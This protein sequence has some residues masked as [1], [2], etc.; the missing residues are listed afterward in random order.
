MKI[1]EFI[2]YDP[3]CALIGN[4]SNDFVEKQTTKSYLSDQLKHAT[5]LI[6]MT[7]LK[8]I[9]LLRM[10]LEIIKIMISFATLSKAISSGHIC[11]MF[12]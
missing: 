12:S 11:Y 6:P 8:A 7:S 5:E 3:I 4:S 9:S 1:V 10:W 2:I